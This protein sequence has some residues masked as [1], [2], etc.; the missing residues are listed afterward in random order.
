[1]LTRREQEVVALL[2]GGLS[3]HEIGRRLY[4]SPKTV[5]HHVSSALTKLGV[6]N[7]AEAAAYAV[8]TDLGGSAHVA[9]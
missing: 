9:R 2:A 7:R 4:I 8:R 6:R 3:N 1:V 5:A